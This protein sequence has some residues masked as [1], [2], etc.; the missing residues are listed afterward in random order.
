MDKEQIKALALKHGFKLKEQPDGTMDLNPYVYE[1]AEALVNPWVSIHE[2]RPPYGLSV[3]IK[4]SGVIQKDTYI[5]DGSDDSLDWFELNCTQLDSDIKEE[6]SFF[7]KHDT[8]LEWR[9]L[10]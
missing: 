2:S 5:L 1:F 4:L 9:C 6:F 3:L 8:N 7:V 10:C